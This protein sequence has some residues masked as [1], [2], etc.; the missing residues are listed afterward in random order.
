MQRCIC[1][2]SPFSTVE[3]THLSLWLWHLSS[4]GSAGC[5]TASGTS[6][7]IAEAALL[8]VMDMRN[9]DWPE[10]RKGL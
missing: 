4:G 7:F 2:S 10:H 6:C 3:E 5:K 1:V 8:L 9:S